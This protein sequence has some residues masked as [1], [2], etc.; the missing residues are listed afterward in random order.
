[1]PPHTYI[2]DTCHL[3]NR[4]K[5]TRAAYVKPRYTCLANVVTKTV[6]EARGSAR[7]R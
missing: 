3:Q 2:P 5:L 4:C 1:M 6:E 7:G